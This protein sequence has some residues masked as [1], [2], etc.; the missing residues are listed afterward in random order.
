MFQ[1]NRQNR[2]STAIDVSGGDGAATMFSQKTSNKYFVQNYVYNN[3]IEVWNLNTSPAENFQINSESEN[4]GDFINVQALDSNFG[5]IYSNYESGGQNQIA[6]FVEWDDFK[7]ADKNE[8][9]KKII[10]SN[11]LLN[12]NVS[13]L[14]VYPDPSKS[15]LFVG[16]ENGQLLKVENANAY[17]GNTNPTS[18]AIWTPITG[19]NFL[20]SIS[21]IEFGKDEDHIFV[22]MYNYGVNNI[23]YTND[24][25]KNWL[26]KDGNLPDLPVYSI[27]QNPLNED[28]VIIGTEL[29]VWFTKD[30]FS[31]NPT[32]KQANAGMRDLRVTDMDLRKGDNTVFIST[33][34]LGIYSG[35]F[36]NNDPNLTL[37]TDKKQLEIFLGQSGS[38][39]INYSA[40]NGFSENVNFSISG[41]PSNSDYTTDPVSPIFI[42]GF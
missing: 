14:T 33:Y 19:S 21:D 28:E 39:K 20:G 7:S 37:D 16:T 30:F 31:E 13:A 10:L 26:K 8:D 29:G 34:G 40:I 2:E 23:F 27:L 24:N 22:T 12:S 5:I 17:T 42:D 4:N 38:F 6:A 25:G 3:S 36:T 11:G 9:A 18:S 1:V 41:L 35:I 15:T 32:W